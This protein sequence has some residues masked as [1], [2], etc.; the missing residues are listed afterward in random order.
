MH[1]ALAT[2][3]AMPGLAGDDRHLLAVLERRGVPAAPVVW[4]DPL[5]DWGGSDVT[6]IRSC[7]D[8]AWRLA[9][10]LAW[11]D[12]AAAA[13]RVLNP[14]EIVRWNAHKR[15]LLD[16]TAADVP[17]VPTVVLERGTRTRLRDV[18][19][20][21]DWPDAVVKAAVGNSGRYARRVSPGSAGALQAWLDRL[22]AREDVLVQPLVR[23]VADAGELSL[24]FIDGEFTHAVRKRSAGADFRV[25]DDYGGSVA[26]EDP[27]PAALEAAERALAAAGGDLMYARVDLVEG[28]AGDL[29]VMEL[30]LIEPELFLRF[31]P[32][33]VERLAD[34]IIRR[35]GA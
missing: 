28:A 7:W 9:P 31:A 34:G 17:A 26:P 14:P 4:E 27:H 16:L 25:H 2:C 10:F 24:V 22:L 11:L 8:Y 12:T 18:L 1:I 15:Y 19:V 6:V 5:A 21:R 29:E 35:C 13:S 30:E 33:A 3:A 32:H 23:S 20:E